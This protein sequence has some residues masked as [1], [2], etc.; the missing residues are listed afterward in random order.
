LKGGTGADEATSSCE[1]HSFIAKSAFRTKRRKTQATKQASSQAR[2]TRGGCSPPLIPP[3][4]VGSGRYYMTSLTCFT[5]RTFL[6]FAVDSVP[7]T[8]TF[9]PTMAALMPLP[10]NT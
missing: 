9:L 4:Q 8:S 6:P 5:V 7:V 10:F 3:N 2:K 1:E